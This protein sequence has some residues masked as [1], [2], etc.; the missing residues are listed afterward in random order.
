M[1]SAL[2]RVGPRLVRRDFLFSPAS[3]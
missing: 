1:S 2:A 3:V